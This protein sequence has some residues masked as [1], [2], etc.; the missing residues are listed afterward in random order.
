[1]FVVSP[2]NPTG[3]VLRLDELK[4]LVAFSTQRGVAVVVDEVFAEYQW[5]EMADGVRM[6]SAQADEGLVFSL[7][8]LSKSAGLPQLKLGW[9]VVGGQKA[10]AREAMARLEVIADT[11]LSVGTPVQ[12]ATPQVLRYADSFQESVR[13]RVLDN[14]RQLTAMLGNRSSALTAL[15]VSAGW[16]ALLRVP[17]VRPDEGWALDLIEKEQVLIHPGAF[18][19]FEQDGY[20]VVSLLARPGTFGE[21]IRRIDA[22][23]QRVVA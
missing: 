19:G 12:H 20:L 1:V 2:N 6:A 16:Y 11:Y 13:M 7:G 8:G 9:V 15:P 14:M 22:F 3:S 10:L 23:V 4:A 18:Y 5:E 17:R 21:A